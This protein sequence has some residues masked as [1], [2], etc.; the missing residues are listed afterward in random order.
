MAATKD[1][2]GHR[3]RMIV[4]QRL[5]RFSTALHDQVTGGVEELWK[6]VEVKLPPS[7]PS[8]DEEK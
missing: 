8:K 2:N 4:S 1:V 3:V 7:Q 5:R 6:R